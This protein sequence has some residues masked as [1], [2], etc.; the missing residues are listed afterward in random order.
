MHTAHTVDT[1]CQR[2]RQV[3]HDSFAHCEEKSEL[4]SLYTVNIVESDLANDYV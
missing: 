1:H 4:P 3:Q 2:S